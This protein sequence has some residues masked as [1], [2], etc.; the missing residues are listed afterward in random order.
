MTFGL[1][2]VGCGLAY[3]VLMGLRHRNR[4]GPLE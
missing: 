3:G 2:I 4:R 1:V